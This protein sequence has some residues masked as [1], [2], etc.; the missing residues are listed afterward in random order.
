LHT[1]AEKAGRFAGQR[2]PR[3]LDRPDT[4]V[5][6]PVPVLDQ[7][8]A[9]LILPIRLVV[10]FGTLIPF[11]LPGI[12]ANEPRDPFTCLPHGAA[13]R[14]MVAELFLRPDLVFLRTPLK[15]VSDGGQR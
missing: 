5:P 14:V 8:V 2:Q 13:L 9:V 12:V 3:L 11:P 7:R 6:R 1:G 15:S 10:L 4:I